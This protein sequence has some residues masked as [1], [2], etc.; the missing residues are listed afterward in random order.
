M[1]VKNFISNKKDKRR[2]I[3]IFGGFL[4]LFLVLMIGSGLALTSGE[5]FSITRE[6]GSRD[7]TVN[8][9]INKVGTDVINSVEAKLGYIDA[10]ADEAT[11][12]FKSDTNWTDAVEGYCTPIA[13]D[14][15]YVTGYGYDGPYGTGDYTLRYVGYGQDY[16]PSNWYSYGVTG[17]ANYAD[18]YGYGYGLNDSGY[19][20]CTFTFTDLNE[21]MYFG[22][23]PILNSIPVPDE[24]NQYF[25]S[26]EESKIFGILD[27][28]GEGE[29]ILKFI[30][31]NADLVGGT[32]MAKLDVNGTKDTNYTIAEDNYVT[33]DI[34]VDLASGSTITGQNAV[35]KGYAFTFGPTGSDFNDG[36]AT[37]TLNYAEA[38]ITTAQVSRARVYH[39]SNSA[40]EVLT[41]NVNTTTTMLE[42]E[43]T[44]FSAFTSGLIN[45][46]PTGGSSSTTTTTTGTTPDTT[47][48]DTTTDEPGTT[49]ETVYNE[50]KTV[51][52]NEEQ[53]EEVLS[54]MT[55]DQGNALFTET[56]IAEMIENSEE[57]EFEV[58]VKVQ[59]IT[60]AEG[61]ASYK[62]TVTTT[63]RNNTGKDQKNV[64]VVVEV[65]KEV[66]ETAS[67]ITSGTIFTVLKD[68]PIL[69]FTLPLVKAGET[70]TV[71]YT[72]TDTEAPVLE[73]VN[74]TEPSV[75]F[76]EEVTIPTGTDD[77][78]ETDTTT[79]ETPVEAPMD[80][81][82]IIIILIVLLVIVGVAY[83]K[84]DDIQKMLK[85]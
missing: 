37:L 33:L 48:D 29:K 20:N 57:Y 5:L 13:T 21:G 36:V 52:Y 74:F 26:F 3:A 9:L 56:E 45:E 77:T 31:P 11:I 49:T 24:N 80:I 39:Y 81:I 55:D 83:Y 61:N 69:E 67:R 82:P 25:I 10:N 64:K 65:P 54:N 84:K 23:Q 18:N 76:A 68:D 22:I 34:D 19:L 47:T 50:T 78:T 2:N 14:Y 62:T 53:L 32:L 17:Y 46:T 66:S 16:Y 85:K 1:N 27:V 6:A 40:W 63:V 43:I 59:K 7:A 58:N 75:R 4:V 70:Q 42:A 35:Q 30:S 8:I 73:G 71:T 15:N 41:T 28:S 38:G 60:D 12:N 79:E 51:N 72:V 44:S